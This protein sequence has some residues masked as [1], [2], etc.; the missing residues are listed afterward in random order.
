MVLQEVKDNL[1]NC[2]RPFWHSL[3]D[4]EYGGFYGRMDINLKLYKDA[5]KGTILNS[6]ILWF[7]SSA[8]ALEPNENDLECAEHA[9]A[10]M[11]NHCVDREYGGVF[12][13]TNYDGTPLDTSKHTYNQ[14][15]AIYGL[16]A[17]YA[18]TKK[19]EALDLAMA[20]YDLIEKKCRDQY[21]YLEAFDRKFEPVSNEKLSENGILA[22][23]TMN[24][25]LHV[26]EAYTELYKVSG[27]PR[28]ADS[29]KWIFGTIAGKVYNPS[30]HRQNVFF[31][32]MMTN[33]I[34][35]QSYGHDIETTWLLD[36]G[37]EVLGDGKLIE[38]FRPITKDLVASVYER[39]YMPD[40][41][42][43]NE[44]ENGIKDTTR[45]WWVQAESMVGFTNAYQKNPA[46]TKYLEAVVAIWE[47]CKKYLIDKRPGGEWFWDV[48]ENGVPSSKKDIVEPWKCPYHAGRMCIELIRR[49]VEPASKGE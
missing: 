14:A 20:L 26:L 47:Y 5:E 32:K 44:A 17:Y 9:Y 10:Y 36:R 22:E 18:V 3:I 38:Q 23:K 31:D 46:D 37:L 11:I 19:K 13:S 15:F 24:T 43:I 40:G 27:S 6:R 33:L 4:H 35:L 7:F 34:D 1:N 12:W 45:I 29:M 25:I 2:I 30:L 42:V 28:V 48:D 8:Y 16:S 41:S 49:G 39:A 21:G